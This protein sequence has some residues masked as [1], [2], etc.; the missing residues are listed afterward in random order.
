MRLAALLSSSLAAVLSSLSLAPNARAQGRGDYLNFESPQ[1]SP[2][3]VARL[4]GHDYLLVC[5]TP[6][7]AVEVYDTIGNRH[8][9]RVRVGLEPVSV[10]WNAVLSRCYVANMAGDSVSIIELKLDDKKQLRATLERTTWVGDEPMDIAFLPDNLTAFVTLN[11][12][13]RMAWVHSL[14]LDPVVPNFYLDLVDNLW[15]PTKGLKHPR[16]IMMVGTKLFVLAQRGSHINSPAGGQMDLYGLDFAKLQWHHIDKLGT[17][18]FNMVA[19]RGGELYVVS[20]DAQNQLRGEKAVAG[21]PFGFLRSYLHRINGAATATPVVVSRDLNAVYKTVAGTPVKREE[22]LAH[23]HDVAIYE[24]GTGPRKVFVAAFN[25]DRIGVITDTHLAGAAWS[26]SRFDVPRAK[27]SSNPMAGPRGLALKYAI[28][29]LHGDPGDTLYCL[30]RLDNSVAV[31]DPKTEKVRSVFALQH[32]PTPDHV[33]EGRRFLYDARLSGNGFGSCAS[34]HFDGRLDGQAWDLGGTTPIDPFR[35]DLVDGIVNSKVHEFIKSG[36]FPPAKGL[37]VTQSLQGLLNWEV[38]PTFRAFVT[39]GPFHWRG[40]RRNFEAFNGAFESLLGG[41]KLSAVDMIKFRDMV[42]SISYPSNPEQLLSRTYSGVFGTADKDDGS[43]AQ[44]GLKLYHTAPLNVCSKRSCVQCHTLP[45]GSNNRLTEI[46]TGQPIETAA[47]RSLQQKERVLEKGGNTQVVSK[48]KLGDF[49]LAHNGGV[50]SI[51]AFNRGAFTGEFPKEPEKVAAINQMNREFDTG[52][53]PLVGLPYTID[54]KNRDSGITLMAM[55]GLEAGALNVDSGLAVQAWISGVKRGFWFDLSAGTRVYREEPSGRVLTRARLLALVARPGDR[56][57]VMGTP[58]GSERRIAHPKGQP[59]ALRGPAPSE[60]KLEPMITSTPYRQVPLLKK[61]WIPKA[62]GGDF[63]WDAKFSSTTTPVPEPLSLLRIRLFQWGLSQDGPEF[64]LEALRH[65]APR[66]LRVSGKNIR[67]G[68]K[69]G[70]WIPNSKRKPPHNEFRELLRLELPIY[71]SGKTLPN[72]NPI[73][74]T[75]VEIEPR[76]YYGMMLGGAYAPGV[77][78]AW[79]GTMKEPPSKGTFDPKGW[80]KHYVIVLNQDITYTA[81]GWQP[82]R[83]Q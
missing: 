21:A 41:K 5:N 19:G 18:N 16:R 31:I 33:R 70:L 77:I 74:E 54:I 81:G 45:E 37:M 68:A 75:A 35:K 26:V 80:N 65:E 73:W 10:K 34:C 49:G 53:G 71:A 67:H 78:P 15:A 69:L 6:D 72:G 51:N 82:L 43:R 64:G 11:S 76:Y 14:T 22:S 44:L 39:N 23:P 63:V 55:N 58:L 2:I 17:V 27:N 38:A 29:N 3:A 4:A 28:G 32:D 66:R 59:D 46:L 36:F 8:L 52:V 50:D 20:G 25:V 7:N 62:F 56:L 47:M 13:S 12:S 1:V 79:N 48:I 83:I 42:N 24:P 30:N 60:I 61:N 57:V 9:A 40:D